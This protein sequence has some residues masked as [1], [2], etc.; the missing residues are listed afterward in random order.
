MLFS[1][2]IDSSSVSGASVESP[3]G[4]ADI[5]NNFRRID[6]DFP[7][8]NLRLF[9]SVVAQVEMA[10]PPCSANHTAASLNVKIRVFTG[11]GGLWI[12]RARF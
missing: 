7:C 2:V 4:G 8:L 6:R 12:M 9:Q 10:G 3:F 1:S 5:L 11:L